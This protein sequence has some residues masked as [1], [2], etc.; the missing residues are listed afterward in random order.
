MTRW[1]MLTLLTEVSLAALL[2][3]LWQQSWLAGAF[4]LLVLLVQVDLAKG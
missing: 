3:G 4:M 2:F 1:K